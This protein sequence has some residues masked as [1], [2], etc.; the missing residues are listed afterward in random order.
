[1]L[2][3]QILEYILQHKDAATLLFTFV[4]ALSTVCYA[5]LTWSLVSETK[6]LREAQTEP[7]IAAWVELTNEF[8]PFAYLRIQNIGLGSAFNICF[9]LTDKAKNLGGQLLIKDFLE[10]PFLNTG[11]EYLGPGQE[12]S[13]RAILFRENLEEKIEAVLVVKIKYRSTKNQEYT[14]IYRLD[15][16]E[17]R[18]YSNPTEQQL[19]SIAN[20]LKQI[21][22]R[23]S[24]F[25]TKP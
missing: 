10:T 17:L 21:E 25:K 15:M 9:Q 4:V 11:I 16:A 23:L 18:S 13:S 19:Q 20:S 7:K 5:F 24:R 12:L 1:M 2:A 3:M 14:E 6:K 8:T 22:R